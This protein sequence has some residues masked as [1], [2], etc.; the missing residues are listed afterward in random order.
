MNTDN[1]E[2]EYQDAMQGAALAFLSRRQGEHLENDQLLFTRTVQHL[3]GSLEVPLYL[4]EKLVARAY[5][6]L[7]AG[8]EHRLLDVDASSTKVAMITD[9]RS[10]LTWAVPVHLIYDRIINAPDS[11]RVRLVKL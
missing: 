9:P 3:V 5:G 2:V 4:A 7:K 10:G 6:E 8:D 1:T 11:R